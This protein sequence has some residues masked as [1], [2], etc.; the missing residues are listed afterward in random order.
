MNKKYALV[1]QC[2]IANVFEV[3]CFNL[4]TFGRDAVRC[5]QNDFRSCENFARGLM[6]GGAQVMSLHCPEAGDITNAQWKDDLW[7]AMFTQ[8][9]NPVYSSGFAH[10]FPENWREIEQQR[11]QQRETYVQGVR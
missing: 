11:E 7:N 10:Y 3:K 4:S 6:L 1:Y 5:I 8:D 9:M 2:G